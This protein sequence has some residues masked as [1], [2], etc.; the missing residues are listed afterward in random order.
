MAATGLHNWV[1]GIFFHENL[2][3]C[4]TSRACGRL[5]GLTLGVVCVD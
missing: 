5:S 2:G 4:K 3:I 1:S